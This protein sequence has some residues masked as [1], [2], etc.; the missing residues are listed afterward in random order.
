MHLRD[1]PDCVTRYGGVH[2]R[3]QFSGRLA[4][5][6]SRVIL[7]RRRRRRPALMDT[8]DRSGYRSMSHVDPQ[9]ASL[10]DCM[11]WRYNRG[12]RDAVY[13]GLVAL[14]V[15][16]TERRHVFA[17]LMRRWLQYEP[18]V[19]NAAER[20]VDEE[21]F[22]DLWRA[23]Q[24]LYDR[25]IHRF[26]L[27]LVMVSSIQQWGWSV[28]DRAAWTDAER[29]WIK[30]PCLDSAIASLVADYWMPPAHDGSPEGP[31]ES[32]FIARCR[33]WDLREQICW[34][35]TRAEVPVQTDVVAHPP[36][37]PSPPPSAIADTEAAALLLGLGGRGAS[38][39][40]TSLVFWGPQ[41]WTPASPEPAP[42]SPAVVV[43]APRSKRTWEMV[44]VLLPA[45]PGSCRR[46]RAPSPPRGQVFVEVVD[47]YVPTVEDRR[48]SIEEEEVEMDDNE[49][50]RK[51]RRT[52]PSVG[53]EG[54]ECAL[55]AVSARPFRC[56]V[57]CVC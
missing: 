51:R 9:Q 42:A 5:S 2:K 52:M 10:E 8:T 1:V 33:D 20:R 6:P 26:G 7:S 46:T 31:E 41:P 47:E 38:P 27:Q 43:E 44:G 30:T 28:S 53:F 4:N 16:K 14:F 18:F 34:A 57:S 11:Q 49:S 25:R 32:R 23:C 45:V 13:R 22:D 56:V 40:P 24:Y 54:G 37:M 50:P 35:D 21:A 29:A 3:A 48:A 15:G 12:I 39:A 36:T 55:Q 17:T 19:L